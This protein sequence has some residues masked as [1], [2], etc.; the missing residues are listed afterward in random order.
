MIVELSI[1]GGDFDLV[2]PDPHYAYTIRSTSTG[3]FPGSFCYAGIISTWTDFAVDLS[4]HQG[5]DLQVRFRFGSDLSV[6]EEGSYIDD[7]VIIGNAD[8]YVPPEELTIFTDPVSGNLVFR[9]TDTG[10]PEYQL[11]SSASSDG[12]FETLAGTSE[13]NSLAIPQPADEMLYYVVVSSSGS[14][15]SAPRKTA[16]SKAEYLK[17]R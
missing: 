11:Y 14:A 17:Q 3:P 9:W 15:L 2:E 10:A 16:M 6:T 12:P 8:P 4:A 13:T 5:S 1:D 7:V